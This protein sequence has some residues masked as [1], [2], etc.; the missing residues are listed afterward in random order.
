MILKLEGLVSETFYG[1]QNQYKYQNTGFAE[2]QGKNLHG[3]TFHSERYST[4]DGSAQRLLQFELMEKRYALISLPTGGWHI[5]LVYLI[6]EGDYH[7]VSKWSIPELGPEPLRFN[8]RST[9]NQFFEAFDS[10]DIMIYN[11]G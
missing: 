8:L 9:L 5:F 7:V 3:L 6:F 4:C 11:K 10:F 1:L 2:F